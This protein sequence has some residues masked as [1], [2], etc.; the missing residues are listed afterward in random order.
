MNKLY[1]NALFMRSI[2]QQKEIFA[3][4]SFSRKK[5]LSLK[6][7]SAKIKITLISERINSA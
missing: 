1:N 5:F 3:L 7:C 6:G 2:N 4:I